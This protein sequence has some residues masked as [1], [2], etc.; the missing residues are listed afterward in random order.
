MS[1]AIIL[2]IR[3]IPNKIKAEVAGQSLGHGAD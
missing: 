2:V 1:K 3:W